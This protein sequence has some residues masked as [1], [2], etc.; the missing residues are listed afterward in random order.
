[1]KILISSL[2]QTVKSSPFVLKEINR[3]FGLY[4]IGFSLIVLSVLGLFEQ[5]AGSHSP[6]MFFTSLTLDFL[7][8]I[9]IVFMIPYYAYKHNN[10]SHVRP[11][12]TFINETVWPVVV[13]QI[14]VFLVL[15]LF[16]FLLIIPA[17]YKAIRYTFIIH[18]VFF[19]DLYK[20]GKLS[21]LKSADRTSRG[22]F[23]LIVLALI[24]GKIF[25]FSPVIFKYILFPFF[26]AFMKSGLLLVLK[27]YFFCL[28]LLFQS[29]FY[30]E[31]K[32]QRGEKIS[33]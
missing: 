18:T 32:K 4:Y 13:S 2:R 5:G 16:F 26:P 30:F 19:D 33:C 11:F 12:W 27:F 3:Y 29:Q 6:V 8:K 21:A 31:L 10:K 22:Y 23:W 7:G 25:A 9:F 17:I 28:V 20:Q 24:F 14:K 15:V 1:M